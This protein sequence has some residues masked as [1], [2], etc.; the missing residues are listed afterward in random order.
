MLTGESLSEL[1]MG[2]L[3]VSG[4]DSRIVFAGFHLLFERLNN[5]LQRINLL[6]LA[7][8]DR[9]Q[10]FKHLLMVGEFYFKVDKARF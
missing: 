9:A 1:V 10:I 8:D 4:P 6:L 7:K 3:I 2:W 5:R